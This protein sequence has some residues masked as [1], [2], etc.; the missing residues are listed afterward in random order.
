MRI[1]GHLEEDFRQPMHVCPV[2]LRKLQILCAFSALQRYQGLLG[3][4][5]K[6]GMAE[7]ASWV[8]RRILYIQKHSPESTTL[9]QLAA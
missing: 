3:F 2:D 1:A 9:T 6:H 5:R 8:D 7:E 4:Y